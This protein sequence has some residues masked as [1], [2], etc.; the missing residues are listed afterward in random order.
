[1]DK[2]KEKKLERISK[3]KGL[4]TLLYI[5]GSK[6]DS[7]ANF[8]ATHRFTTNTLARIRKLEPSIEDRILDLKEVCLLESNEKLWS[9]D[10]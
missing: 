5:T 1:M 4:L 10:S 3:L 9:K 6:S 2:I 7:L 8:N